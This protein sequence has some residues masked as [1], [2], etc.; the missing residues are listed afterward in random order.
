MQQLLTGKKRLPGF[1]EGKG[2]QQTEVGV[3]PEDWKVC[4]LGDAV[5]FLDGKRK[6]IKESNRA[7]MHGIYPYYGASGIVDYVNNYLFNED[8]ILLGEDGENIL[9]RSVRLA[10]RVSEKIW[11]NNHA[12]VLKP[13]LDFDI[14]FLTEYLESL[15]YSLYNSGTAQPKLNQ[16]TCQSIPIIQPSQEEQQEIATVISD[17]DAE[18]AALETRLA[19][20]QS[21]KQGMMQQLLTGKV[22]LK[23]KAGMDAGREDD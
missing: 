19:K 8:L 11:V 1:G 6:P 23:I 21:V 7:K 14:G 22:R 13:K 20:T 18:I 2:D 12:H 5:D 10:F 16:Q 4:T 15:D 3:I 17:M 9:S